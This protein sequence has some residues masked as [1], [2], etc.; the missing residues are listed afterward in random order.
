MTV[1]NILSGNY[2]LSIVQNNRT[3]M[4]SI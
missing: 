3:L 1:L 4:L 2:F